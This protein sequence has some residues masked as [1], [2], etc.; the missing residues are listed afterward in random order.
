MSALG[1]G[2]VPEIE[3]YILRISYYLP[4]LVSF[5]E[6][7]IYYDKGD[8]SYIKNGYLNI[9]QITK[10]LVFQFFSFFIS[11]LKASGPQYMYISILIYAT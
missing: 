1:F 3:R 5:S 9:L 11:V 6:A 7:E 4:E 8:N 10:T 2:K